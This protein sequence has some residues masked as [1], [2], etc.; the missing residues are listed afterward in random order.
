MSGIAG[1]I[2]KA[3]KNK[4]SAMLDKI[5]HRGPAGRA[6]FVDDRVVLCQ[7]WHQTK[8]KSTKGDL[9]VHTKGD[10]SIVFDG[11]LTN[12]N[13]IALPGSDAEVVLSL[14]QSYKEECLGMLEGMFAFALLDKKRLL[15]ARDPFGIRPLYLGWDSDTIYFASEIKALTFAK[16][17][18]TFP[19][20]RY[21]WF[22]IKTKNTHPWYIPYFQLNLKI[23]GQS[24]PID[25]AKRLSKLLEK[26]ISAC[27]R[28]NELVGSL[29][30]GGI[31]SSVITA[32]ACKTA[33]DLGISE[34]HTYCIGTPGSQ[35]L[36]YAAL[37]AD[38]LGTVHHEYILEEK[39]VESLLPTIVYHLESFDA[40]LVRSSVANYLVAREAKRHC[41]ALLCGEGGDE[42]FAGYEFLDGLTSTELLQAT[43]KM[44]DNSHN[45][46]LQRDDR[47]TACHG[48]GNR[49][50][51]FSIDLVDFALS[52]D[53]RL[54]RQD[55]IEK[56]IFRK[57]VEKILPHEVVWRPK[58][59]FWSGSGS[60]TLLKK[61]TEMIISDEE[62]ASAREQFS[63]IGIKSK[64]EL[65]YFNIFK[66]HFPA[67][68]I[69]HVGRTQDW[70][71][72]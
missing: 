30:S 2:G 5:A 49:V 67:T 68:V 48:L 27:L 50:P 42:L 55:G 71:P 38:H 45:T 24:N 60:D 69:E 1:I 59:K 44:L 65:A 13:A 6:V 46:A 62:F 43:I 3:D 12:R 9:E 29:L 56:Y 47:M 15:L 25:V 41:C 14:Y 8:K 17:I 4:A 54:K 7:N 22:D 37:V 52:V 21:A 31:D 28:R 36:K 33:K 16:T 26:N 58:A 11:F 70:R 18:Q 53:Q 51:F 57:S 61:I 34:W 32:F 10:I 23:G 39:E 72:R 19:P 66:E 20:G 35:D 40:P 64:E 63:H